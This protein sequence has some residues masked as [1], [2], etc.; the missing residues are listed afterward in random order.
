MEDSRSERFGALGGVVFV[1][2]DVAVAILG[3]E[4]PAT[5]AG[6]G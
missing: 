3:G 6:L 5:D 1:V 2:L 4:P